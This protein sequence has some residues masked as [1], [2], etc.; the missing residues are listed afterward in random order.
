MK[1]VAELLLAQSC[2]VELL[3]DSD[4]PILAAF[5]VFVFAAAGLESVAAAAAVVVA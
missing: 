2:A 3:A 4:P 1:H 5:V